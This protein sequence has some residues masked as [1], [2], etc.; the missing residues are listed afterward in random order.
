MIWLLPGIA[1]FVCFLL[2]DMEKANGKRYAAALFFAGV[3]LLAI[4]TVELFLSHVFEWRAI[5]RTICGVIAMAWFF[6][7][8]YVLFAALPAKKVY[9]GENKL[10][11]CS[12]GVYALCR[13][14]GGW[15]F[16]F[17]YWFL[18]L[19]APSAQMLSAAIVFPALNFLYIGVQDCYFFP[20]YIEGYDS[21]KQLVPFL[22]PTGHSLRKFL[23]G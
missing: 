7:L 23:N 4:S 21:Y 3:L 2:F 12:K 18:W 20:K 1:S 19:Y 22:F 8:L 10:Q 15:C 9:S 13:H 14:P 17:L 5:W 11:V 16:L 6:A